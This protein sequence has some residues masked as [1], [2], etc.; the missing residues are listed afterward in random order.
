MRADSVGLFW[1][2]VA[3]VKPPKK[4]KV[5]RDPPH[6]FWKEPGY[7]PAAALE[8]ARKYTFDFIQDMELIAA[9]KLGHRM[10]YDVESYKN[11]G[12]H[13]FKNI[14]TGRYLIFEIG[15]G[16]DF[17]RNKFRWIMENFTLITFNGKFYDEV[18]ANVIANP[19]YGYEDMQNATQLLIVEGMRP[20]EVLKHYG[21]TKEKKLKIDQI[22]IIELTALAPSLKKCAAR[23]HAPRL[24]DLPFPP[25]TD[26][27]PEQ[28][29]VL[30]RYNINDLDNTQ[31]VYESK[32]DVLAIRE[33]KSKEYGVDLRSDSDA[34]MAEG[35]IKA[36]IKRMTGRKFIQ[37]TEIPAG[38]QYQYK[39]PHFI[40]FHTVMMNSMLDILR[41]ARFTINHWDGGL[42]MPP[43]IKNLVLNIA[44]G[45]YQMGI[46][47]LHSKEKS[48]AYYAGD[49]YQI[50]DTDAT[51]YYPTLI[52]NAGL[53]P[54]SLGQ[55][56]L[57]VYHKIVQERIKAKHAGDDV[58]AQ[59]LK[60]V[61]NGTFGKL[62]SM[63]SIMYAP[64]LMLQVTVTGQLCLLMLIERFELAGIQVINA[65]TDGVVARP[66]ESQMEVFK[67]IVKQWEKETGFGTEETHYKAY[68]AKDVN[69]YLAQ[70]VK[71]EKGQHFKTKGLYAKT[72]SQKNAV[73]EVCI[74]ALKEYLAHGTPVEETIRNCKK[75]SMFTTMREL[76]Q[77][78]G[79]V[80][81]DAYL[82]KVVRWYYGVGEPGEIVLAKSGNKVPRSDGAI[83]VMDLPDSLPADLD[84]DWYIRECYSILGKIG[85]EQKEEEEEETEEETA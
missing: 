53:A 10:V 5:K 61:I 39:V 29:L 54:M 26:L 85:L 49:G 44:D 48:R 36:E 46:G 63:W 2:D 68:L 17:D 51:S 58:T 34:Q 23:L 62:G 82:G 78:G 12:L 79:A 25:G 15:P 65:N 81:G 20:H 19:R 43:E 18:I 60:I 77:G 84:Y 83:P 76:A 35:I 66:H 11:Y 3:K 27:S 59:C 22:D 52:L 1:E 14:V 28:M 70:Y 21:I 56:F 40:K 67:A 30:K 32:L 6:P 69:N 47:G 41:S 57:T 64:D 73:N 7:I 75:L 13:G 31:I 4:E 37:R 9:Q 24:Q 72:S 33:Q 50:I 45:E 74:L 42:L 16:F 8:E 55:A 38:T 80:K 71:P